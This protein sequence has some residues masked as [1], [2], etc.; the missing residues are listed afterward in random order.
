MFTTQSLLMYRIMTAAA[1]QFSNKS[2]FTTNSQPPGG[3]GL[4]CALLKSTGAQ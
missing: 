2:L 3:E 1:D 4:V